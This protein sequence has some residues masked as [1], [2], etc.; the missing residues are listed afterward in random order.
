MTSGGRVY[1]LSYGLTAGGVLLV[2]VINILNRLQ[3]A[4]VHALPFAALT[5]VLLEGSS[6]IVIVTLIPM[7]WL[8][9]RR[10]PPRPEAWAKT[11][12]VHLG[13]ATVFSVVH[14]G[15]MV[16]LRALLPPLRGHAD[17]DGLN[18]FFYEYRKDV[19]VYA[20]LLAS[21]MVLRH[22]LQPRQE[23]AGEVVKANRS[24]PTFDIR[25]G[26]RILRTPVR[27]IAAV[28]S[29]GNYVEVKLIDGRSPLMR[30][31]LAG[32]EAQLEE[33]GF[34]R[35]HRSWLVNPARVRVIAP[36]GSGD[37]RLELDGGLEAPLSRRYGGALERLRSPT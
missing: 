13:C 28:V 11:A 9:A 8:A 1:W 21:G 12:V 34:L 19:L 35:T 18:A 3:E 29:A 23:A 6:T 32:M 33:H 16:G 20:V 2:T 31:T 26:A 15:G 17:F 10:W 36:V 30:A 37:H 22:L 25:D 14:V 5:T 4:R 27:D 7:I 24:E